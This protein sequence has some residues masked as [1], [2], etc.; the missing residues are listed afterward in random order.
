MNILSWIYYFL[1]A[2]CIVLIEFFDNLE[3]KI[4][5]FYSN[6]MKTNLDNFHLLLTRNEESFSRKNVKKSHYDKIVGI[7]VDRKF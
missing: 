4:K 6:T 5:W 1:Q 7:T 3:I 2:P